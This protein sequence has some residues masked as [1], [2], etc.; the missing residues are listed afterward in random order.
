[1]NDFPSF[2]KEQVPHETEVFKENLRVT[3]IKGNAVG[4]ERTEGSDN[5]SKSRNNT[6]ETHT[7]S[8]PEVKLL[9]C[10]ICFHY[11]V[12]SHQQTTNNCCGSVTVHVNCKINDC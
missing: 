3:L 11:I 12:Y 1:M 7:Q 10:S 2:K 4:D 9:L 8:T 6:N 5:Y